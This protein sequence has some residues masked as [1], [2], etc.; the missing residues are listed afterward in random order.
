MFMNSLNKPLI[1]ITGAPRSGTSL[2]TKVIDAHPDIAILMEN[3]FGN[4]RRHWQ[5]EAF[6]Q[7][8]EALR[9]EV[10]KVYARLNEPVVGNKV[11]IPDVWD[12]GDILQFCRLFN[13]FKIIFMARDPRAAALSRLKREPADFFEVFSPTARDNILLDFRDRFHTYISSWRQSI[14]NFWKLRDG[15]GEDKIKIVYY[16][17]FCRDFENQVRDIFTFLDIPFSNNILKWYEF[18]HHNAAGELVHDLKYPDSEI[19]LPGNDETYPP[20]LEKAVNG[21]TWQYDLWKKRRL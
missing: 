2:V 12:A 9:C 4:R 5:R 20:G 16:E 3:I 21:I 14:E 18:S 1:F 17:D 8:T 7:S 6:W 10:A 11:V 15:L 13:R 19:F